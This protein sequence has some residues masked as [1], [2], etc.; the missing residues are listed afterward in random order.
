MQIRVQHEDNRMEVLTLVPP[1]S[2]DQGKNMTV[3]RDASGMEHWF[4]EEGYYDGWD[5]NTPG[6]SSEDMDRIIERVE[7]SRVIEEAERG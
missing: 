1:T 3:I 5:I 7:G 4:T 2:V 6:A